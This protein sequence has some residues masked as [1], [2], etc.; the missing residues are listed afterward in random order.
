MKP[1]K[2]ITC[3]V[4]VFAVSRLPAQNYIFYL[5]GKII[6]NKGPYAV[7]SVSGYG[8][9]R[10]YDILDSI[11][12]RGKF[13]VI[14]E[15]RGKNTDVKTYA[16]KV[17]RQIDSL[18]NKKVAP[19]KITVI[20][21]SK[22]SLI[23]MYVSSYVKN[24]DVNYVFMAACSDDL[25]DS[26]PELEFNG[27]ILSIYEKSDFARSCQK[28]K[29]RSKNINHYKEIELNTNLRHG[30]LYKPLSEWVHPSIKWATGDYK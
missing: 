29:E 19:Q 21:A 12:A 1:L 20:G 30:F 22:G 4:V 25:F 15:V 5:H 6:E 16:Q 3:I 9:Y 8:A 17:K 27:N 23:A 18:L 24:K 11:S 13:Y 26:A 7:D 10:Y 14:S 28:F 2:L